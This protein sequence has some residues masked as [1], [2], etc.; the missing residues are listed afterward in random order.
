MV[1]ASI[2]AFVFQ[3]LLLSFALE[4]RR[5]VMSMRDLVGASS[6][7][8]ALL[9]SDECDDQQEQGI[10][11]P[12]RHGAAAAGLLSSSEDG[13]EARETIEA[14]TRQFQTRAGR[15]VRRRVQSDVAAACDDDGA[16]SESSKASLD[17]AFGRKNPNR[18][19]RRST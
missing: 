1:V 14:S 5:L 6:S 4:W 12:L 10:A 16:D 9:E 19:V 3:H 8:R 13:D 17:D 15:P 18:Y 2:H 7:R 11:F